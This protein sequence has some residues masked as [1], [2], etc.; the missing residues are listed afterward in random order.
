[1]TADLELV[2]KVIAGDQLAFAGLVVLG[3]VTQDPLDAL[4]LAAVVL[5]AE[6]LV[7]L[8]AGTQ[9]ACEA[10]VFGQHH[11]DLPLVLRLTAPGHHPRR[12][13]LTD[14]SETVV[15][16]NCSAVLSDSPSVT[17]SW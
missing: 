2:E 5:A 6:V 8:Q 7:R 1:M 9:L 17:C 13:L 3:D 15:E 10:V 14:E 16:E 4:A 12:F 11:Q